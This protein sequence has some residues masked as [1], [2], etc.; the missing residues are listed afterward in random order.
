MDRNK[1]PKR[2]L[3][4]EYAVSVQSFAG[5][6]LNKH[7]PGTGRDKHGRTT[8]QHVKPK[9]EAAPVQQRIHIHVAPPQTPA[10]KR[11]EQGR[12]QAEPKTVRI[13]EREKVIVER[14]TIILRDVVR[15]MD[16]QRQARALAMTEPYRIEDS[17][18]HRLLPDSALP[19]IRQDAGK[20]RQDHHSG[21]RPAATSLGNRIRNQSGQAIRQSQSLEK[22]RRIVAAGEVRSALAKQRHEHTL[23]EV[24]S[25]RDAA[26]HIAAKKRPLTHA[27]RETKS[28]DL[29]QAEARAGQQAARSEQAARRLE[30]KAAERAEKKAADAAQAAERAEKKAARPAQAEKKKARLEQ[31]ADGQAEPTDAAKKAAER[32]EMTAARAEQAENRRMAKPSEQEQAAER[33][34]EQGTRSQAAGKTRSK[35]EGSVKPPAMPA[36]VHKKQKP[37]GEDDAATS[38]AKLRPVSLQAAADI[39]APLRPN[40]AHSGTRADSAGGSDAGSGE[41]SGARGEQASVGGAPLE[42]VFSKSGLLR[43]AGRLLFLSPKWIDPQ[44]SGAERRLRNK[45]SGHRLSAMLPER[46]AGAAAAGKPWGVPI[47]ARRFVHRQNGGAMP[48]ERHPSVSAEASAERTPERSG[49]SLTASADTRRQRSATGITPSVSAADVYSRT[50]IRDFLPLIAALKQRRGHSAAPRSQ[51]QKKIGPDAFASSLDRQASL[52]IAARRS[53]ARP[54]KPGAANE[55]GAAA[56]VS[57]RPGSGAGTIQHVAVTKGL[58]PAHLIARRHGGT[59]D[60]ASAVK[61]SR[62]GMGSGGSLILAPNNGQAPGVSEQGNRRRNGRSFAAAHLVAASSGVLQQQGNSERN[63]PIRRANAFK[64]IGLVLRRMPENL[65]ATLV[66]LTRSNRAISGS[67]ASASTSGESPRGEALTDNRRTQSSHL[68]QASANPIGLRRSTIPATEVKAAGASVS[69]DSAGI[70]FIVPTGTRRDDRLRPSTPFLS[71][72]RLRSAG[73]ANDGAKRQPAFVQRSVGMRQEAAAFAKRQD[74]VV[75]TAANSRTSRDIRQSPLT[76]KPFAARSQQP[77]RH[78]MNGGGISL[79]SDGSGIT[80]PSALAYSRERANNG[81][82]YGSAA[83]RQSSAPEGPGI[84]S[85]AQLGLTHRTPPS[86]PAEPPRQVQVEAPRELEPEKL[87]RM[88]MKMPQLNPEAIADRVYKALERKMK[89]EQRRNGF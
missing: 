41:R 22:L 46:E 71:K 56:P 8:M 24:A 19:N 53:A 61:P 51:G 44:L 5:S 50:S 13:V 76:A 16:N 18:E 66:R 27:Q 47:E 64:P 84:T 14:E 73:K 20:R 58:E 69:A 42:P 72:L 4:A 35:A 1:A 57:G 85:G 55:S 26:A 33:A 37:E 88:I 43:S 77:A 23:R 89:L 83:S 2:R 29:E 62:S 34:G 75:Q 40:V 70:A 45:S 36:M 87:Q 59:A 67:P 25:S 78:G 31:A 74:G 10:A 86:A 38:R 6:I 80:V 12:K 28:A 32:A 48:V 15:I 9:A 49:A 54:D 79:R 17:T 3:A 11:Q 81:A 65:G 21:P 68:H 7:R 30:R 63:V 60:A 52:P 39:S 82:V